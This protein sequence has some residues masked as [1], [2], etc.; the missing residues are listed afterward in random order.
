VM[1]LQSH[2]LTVAMTGDGSAVNIMFY[3]LYKFLWV[4]M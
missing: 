3:N 2:G 1:A 4:F